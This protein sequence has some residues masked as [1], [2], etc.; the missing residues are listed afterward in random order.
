MQGGLRDWIRS[1]NLYLEEKG[2]HQINL[3][4]ERKLPHDTLK[5]QSFEQKKSTP[6][7]ELWH[8]RLYSSWANLST[9]QQISTLV[10]VTAFIFGIGFYFGN[11]KFDYDRVVVA[12]DRDKYKKRRDQLEKDL[13]IS[14]DTVKQL[15]TKQ[16]L[17]TSELKTKESEIGKLNSGMTAELKSKSTK[18]QNVVNP[19]L[20][21]PYTFFEAV[22]KLRLAKDGQPCDTATRIERISPV[23]KGGNSVV[24]RIYPEYKYDKWFF[25]ICDGIFDYKLIGSNQSF[26]ASIALGTKEDKHI[27]AKSPYS[28]CLDKNGCLIEYIVKP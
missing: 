27:Y 1:I 22:L 6:K 15:L 23:G 16:E 2:E 9:L 10:T 28:K 26:G 19:D 12:S 7:E 8:W 17:L 18:P 3:T 24:F 21:A 20:E 5:S 13:K 4:P 25:Q 11:L 14:R